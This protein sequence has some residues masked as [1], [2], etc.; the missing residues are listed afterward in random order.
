M[1]VRLLMTADAV[2][3]V[4]TYALELARALLPYGVETTIA[5][6]GPEP[7]AGQAA[8]ASDIEGL[9]IETST[10]ALEWM[11]D[12][13]VD[14]ERA[15]RWLLDLDRRV[16]PS[17][18]HLNGFAH[19][20]LPWRCPVVV[21]GHSCVASWRDAVGGSFDERWMQRYRQTVSAG[22][23]AADWVI[24]P[25]A[26]MLAALQRHY[27]PLRR[28]SVVPNGRDSRRF[29]RVVKEPFI[30]TAGRLW[31]RAKNVEAVDA[32][33]SRVGWRVVVAQGLTSAEIAERLS[34]ASIFVLPARYEPFGLLA[35]EAALSGCALVLGDIAS[36][37]EVWGSEAIYVAP[38]DR[39]ALAARLQELIDSPAALERSA[40]AA[41][42]HAQRYTPEA[43]AAGYM[44]VYRMVASETLRCAS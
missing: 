1:S 17:L 44:R 13:W 10:F 9:E 8:E 41:A 33:A 20:T 38:D 15:G 42:Q 3:G 34:R 18:V 39:D 22:I 21:V 25:S 31:D 35:L 23:R 5:T 29:R 27:G 30:F 32:I 2:G 11:D 7:T 37:R 24:A 14:L 28:A 19:G 4:W 6:M 43:M 12:P 26:E 16:R 36:L 40:A